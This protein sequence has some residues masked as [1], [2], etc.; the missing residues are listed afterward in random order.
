MGAEV[1][2]SSAS[3][4]VL[5][6]SSAFP[7]IS[8]GPLDLAPPAVPAAGFASPLGPGAEFWHFLLEAIPPFAQEDVFNP[9]WSNPTFPSLAQ[10]SGS[11]SAEFASS[12]CEFS[13]KFLVFFFPLGLWRAQKAR[14]GEG[15]RGE[16][17]EGRVW[18]REF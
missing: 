14:G 9:G 12:L 3:P 15:R 8:R 1:K 17:R 7:R 5:S 2:A 11:D 10:G 18:S 6:N 16:E 13:D 4:W